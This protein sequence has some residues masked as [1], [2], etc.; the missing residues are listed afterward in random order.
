MKNFFNILL[1]AH[2]EG[3]G[4][5][6][7]FEIKVQTADCPCHDNHCFSV[8]TCD[9]D[10]PLHRLRNVPYVQWLTTRDGDWRKVDE[11][12][13]ANVNHARG[14]KWEDKKSIAVYRGAVNAATTVRGLV[15]DPF[16]HKL[17]LKDWLLYGRGRLLSLRQEAG[18]ERY[19]NVSLNLG[20]WVYIDGSITWEK[21]IE[22]LH[23]D[24]PVYLTMNEQA[25]RFKYFI[26]A[27]GLCGWADRLKWQLA[28]GQVPIMQ[29][30]RCGEWYTKLLKPWVHYIPVD[31]LFK[32][33]TQAIE[34]AQT[35]D[36]EARRMAEACME[37]AS[38]VITFDGILNYTRLS[39]E[40]YL[41]RLPERYRPKTASPGLMMWHLQNQTLIGIEH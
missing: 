23:M 2:A 30:T 19:M 39:V 9:L 13:N 5:F 32:N 1:S 27:E 17:G 36:E 22:G 8:V 34:W 31:G 18:S 7:N 35:H 24:E 28:M 6:P 40:A 14:L 26:Y 12:T 29:E 11:R 33:L 16:T 41:A 21:A 38:N 3:G 15:N 20:H 4:N 25:D 10:H 37:F